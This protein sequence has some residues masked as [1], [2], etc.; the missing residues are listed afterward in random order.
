MWPSVE[1]NELRVALAGPSLQKAAQPSL[2]SG[3][4][5][6]CDSPLEGGGLELTVPPRKTSP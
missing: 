1:R 5:G 3:T 4:D 6:L 2:H